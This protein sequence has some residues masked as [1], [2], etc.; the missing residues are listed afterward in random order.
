MNLQKKRK[1]II[2]IQKHTHTTHEHVVK[3]IRSNYTVNVEQELFIYFKAR[4]QWVLRAEQNNK[5]RNFK[6]ACVN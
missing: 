6:F 3:E 2:K 5:K 4:R 1:K